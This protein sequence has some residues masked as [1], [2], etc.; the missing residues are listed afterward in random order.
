MS[1]IKTVQQEINRLLLESKTNRW[2]VYN[3][4]SY[5]YDLC[6]VEDKQ[7][8]LDKFYESFP[9]HNPDSN[10]DYWKQQHQRWKELWNQK[11]I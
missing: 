8:T 5:Y 2:T 3:E 7:I 9:Y 4:A 10:C 11:E 1:S 6:S